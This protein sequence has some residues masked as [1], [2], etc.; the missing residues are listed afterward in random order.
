MHNTIV[1][2][3]AVDLVSRLD[4]RIAKFIFIMI[5]HDNDII[6][7]NVTNSIALD[8]SLAKDIDICYTYINSHIYSDLVTSLTKSK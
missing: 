1:I 6:N 8:P 5:N 3:L 2:N 4:C 7:D